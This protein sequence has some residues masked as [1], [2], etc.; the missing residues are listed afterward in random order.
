METGERSVARRTGSTS[1]TATLLQLVEGEYR[2][3]P[4]LAL[5]EAQ[6]ERLWGIDAAMCRAVLTA[7]L[8]R[9]FLRRTAA[10]TYVRAWN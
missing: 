4:G 7:L 10:G 9:R 1:P 3:M 8:D 6:A 5:T 2:E